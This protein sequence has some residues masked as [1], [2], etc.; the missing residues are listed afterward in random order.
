MNN[1]WNTIPL[2]D[3]EL[4]MQHE[5]VRQIFKLIPE[6]NLVSIA[7]KFGFRKIDY[8]ENILPN[9]KSLKTYTFVK[10]LRTASKADIQ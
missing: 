4:H 2:E 1:V 9:K 10:K 7:D 6:G 8:E 5:S 3:Y